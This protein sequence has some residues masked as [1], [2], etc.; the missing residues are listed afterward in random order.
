MTI[1]AETLFIENFITGVALLVLTGKLRRARTAKWR[2]VAGAAMCGAYAFVLFATMHWTTAL[3]SKLL[4]SVAVVLAAFGADTWRSLIK[5]T[6]VFYIVSF[7]MGGITIALMYMMKIPG[8]SANGSFVLKG[9]T[10]LH[11]ATGV[12]VTWYL[13]SWLAG[14]LRE[15]MQKEKVFRTVEL[16]IGGCVW[17]LKALVDT[18]NSLRD[19][20]TGWPVA[21]LSGDASEKI[22]RE[23][24][25]EQ[26]AKF[27]AIPY[28]TV[29]R[30][31]IMF[32]LR[33]ERI[34][35][36][37][38]EI[39]KII[40]GFSEKNFSPWNGCEKYDLLL[41][42]QFLEGEEMT[43]GQEYDYDSEFAGKV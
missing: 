12:A 4:F 27:S 16:H 34:V 20:L 5:T 21:V 15:K 11:V 3:I 10:F 22:Y 28:R 19:P 18:G 17:T 24:D 2:I 7:L 1:Y 35:I 9:A 14:L 42:Q 43:N 25:S 36:E 23:C 41:H 13:G 39:K 37:G 40:L 8:M 6:A 32:G 26:F 33:P 38:C 30:T 29:G 31:G